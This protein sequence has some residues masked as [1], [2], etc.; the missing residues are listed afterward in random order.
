MDSQARGRAAQFLLAHGAQSLAWGNIGVLGALLPGSEGEQV[1][2]V[3]PAGMQREQG[4]YAGFV[5]GM[6]EDGQ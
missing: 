5:V 2:V 3:A 4:A 6:R 1:D